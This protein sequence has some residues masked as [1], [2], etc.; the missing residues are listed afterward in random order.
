[1]SLK[2][3]GLGHGLL[4]IV[5]LERQEHRDDGVAGDLRERL[6]AVAEG[7]PVDRGGPFQ[8]RTGRRLGDSFGGG[9]R[10]RSGEEH[11]AGFGRRHPRGA[12]RHDVGDLAALPDLLADHGYRVHDHAGWLSLRMHFG[13]G[14]S[15]DTEAVNASRATASGSPRTSGTTTVAGLDRA[16][17]LPAAESG[18]VS[19]WR[20]GH[21]DASDRSHLPDQP[22][23][24][25][26]KPRKGGCD[27]SL[28]EA[29]PLPRVHLLDWA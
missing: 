5:V 21:G 24:P 27:R 20:P 3:L 29:P 8:Y 15:L 14:S 2:V 13:P 7:I 10:C 11:V 18:G 6:D 1:M 26:S 16:E 23:N 19:P 9:L 4:G 12:D 28:H 17:K 25:R 22:G